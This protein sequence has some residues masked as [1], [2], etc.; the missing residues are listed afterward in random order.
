MSGHNGT[1]L[2]ASMGLQLNITYPRK[3]NTVGRRLFL[4]AVLVAEV[5]T[6]V[7]HM[8]SP[9]YVSDPAVCGEGPKAE[10]LFMCFV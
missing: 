9:R 4:E 6:G 2:L 1:C 7:G 8:F 10:M 5:Y 3:D